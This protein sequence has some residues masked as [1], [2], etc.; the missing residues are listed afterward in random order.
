MQRLKSALTALAVGIVLLAALDF[1]ASAATGRGMVLGH[2]NQADHKTVLKNTKQG[3][4]LDLRTKS[5]P[6]L[7]VN[8]SKRI[9][10][11]N[12]D[13][14]DGMTGADYKTNRNTLYQWSTA[15]HTGGFTQ[16]VPP[17]P[18]GSYLVTYSVQLTGAA[19]DPGSPNVINCRVVQSGVS[20]AVTFDKAI[21][22]ETT[23]T[24][25]GTPPA[26]NGT[27]PAILA[28]GDSLRLA[29]T[30]TRN[31]QQW[32]TTALQPLQISLLHVDGTDLFA[33]I[34][35]RPTTLKRSTND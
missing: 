2:W 13:E 17:Q 6:V 14:L 35:A 19:G 33:G 22:G 1:A 27:G 31:N 12:A 20:G 11:L 8:N 5:G 21:I 32:S 15:S 3:V 29:C 4:A 23:V 24:S 18:A 10:K 7:K 34:L 28:A 26:L 16:P 25:V 30:M 9:K